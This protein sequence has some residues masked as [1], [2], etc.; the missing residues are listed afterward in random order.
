MRQKRVLRIELSRGTGGSVY[1]GVSPSDCVLSIKHKLETLTGIP[2]L[3]Q[4]LYHAA[5]QLSDST[6]LHEF[7]G[8]TPVTNLS[9]HVPIRGGGCSFNM[10]RV[11]SRSQVNSPFDPIKFYDIT[12]NK[13]FKTEKLAPTAPEY[14]IVYK[15]M[16]FKARCNN[17]E[18]ESVKE[19]HSVYI[20]KGISKQKY[21]MGEEKTK[22]K[23][24]VCF[25]KIPSDNWENIVFT[26]CRATIEWVSGDEQSCGEYE[27]HVPS[28]KYA[29]AKSNQWKKNYASFE[30]KVNL[31]PV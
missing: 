22:M 1:V 16:N 14:M 19:S 30:I 13:C 17:N 9:L 11:E 3:S 15:G 2:V 27:I 24:P 20:R 12:T 18:C 25:S 6:P 29:I 10:P 23:C 21:D 7:C 4:T 28:N 31:H 8:T 5:T 26:N